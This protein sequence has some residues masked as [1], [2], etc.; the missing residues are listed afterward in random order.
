MELT[1][2]ISSV[3]RLAR[4]C[5]RLG[6][7]VQEVDRSGLKLVFRADHGDTPGDDQLFHEATTVA[8]VIDGRPDVG[9]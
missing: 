9:A 2:P 4:S 8:D 5:E 7:A 1:F 3:S 6:H